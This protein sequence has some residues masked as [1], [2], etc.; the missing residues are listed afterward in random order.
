MGTSLSDNDGSNPSIY[1][2]C[3]ISV[4]GLFLS[5]LC[6]HIQASWI[7]KKESVLMLRKLRC[8]GVKWQIPNFIWSFCQFFFLTLTLNLHQKCRNR[9][10]AG[11]ECSDAV[12]VLMMIIG[13]GR[14][15]LPVNNAGSSPCQWIMCSCYSDILT[16]R[17]TRWNVW[18]VTAA[19]NGEP[20][21]FTTET[22]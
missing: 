19:L 10:S 22:P 16:Y 11:R 3:H 17:K 14:Q 15:H 12:A 21:W 20:V 8:R 1:P 2:E 5:I 13:F 6:L 7:S 9:P 18:S 4:C